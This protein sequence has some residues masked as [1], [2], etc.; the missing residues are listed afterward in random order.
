MVIVRGGGIVASRVLQRLMEDR[1]N[2]GAPTTIVHLF[3]TFVSGTQDRGG[4]FYRRKGG[5]G[6]AYQ[7]FNWPKGAWGGQLKDAFDRL[8][9]EERAKLYKKLG[10]THTPKRQAVAAADGPSPPRGLV[11]HRA[12]HGRTG[13]PATP[14]VRS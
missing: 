12:R 1:W 3:R 8:E 4:A 11:P 5:N 14:T 13:R 7:G 6:W 2:H 10:G 9:G